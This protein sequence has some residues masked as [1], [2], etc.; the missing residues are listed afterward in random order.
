[1]CE[2]QKKIDSMQKQINSLEKLV[3]VLRE[4]VR[5]ITPKTVPCHVR[6]K[7]IFVECLDQVSAM[8]GVSCDIILSR[9]KRPAASW[10]RQRLMALCV[11]KGMAGADVGRA[12]GRG[13]D[14]VSDGIRAHKARQK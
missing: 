13:A 10:A 6:E 5:S 9:D 14:T 3:K 2:C 8:T 1:M 11:E 12:L 4:N 7:A